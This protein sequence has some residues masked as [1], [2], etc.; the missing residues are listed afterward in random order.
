MYSDRLEGEVTGFSFKS[1][2]GSFA[3]AK[4]KVQTGAEVV[5][6]GTGSGA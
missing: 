4:V 6:V 3:V 2:D 1:G 5:A